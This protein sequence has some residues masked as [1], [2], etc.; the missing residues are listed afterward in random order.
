M[1]ELLL[2]LRVVFP[3]TLSALEHRDVAEIYRMLEWLVR[4]VAELTFSIGERAQIDR[5]D[6]RPGLH[7]RLRIRGVIDHR[8]TYITVIGDD[9]SVLAY[10]VAVVTS[11]AT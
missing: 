9:L 10:V 3:M 8:M 2:R 5:V 6:K 7:R 4:L 1:R 11:E